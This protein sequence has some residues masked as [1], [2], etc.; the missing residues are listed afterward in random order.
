MK[1]RILLFLLF[2]S[3]SL[4]AQSA[5]ESITKTLQDYMQGSS[6]NQKTQLRSAFAENATLYLTVREEFKQLSADEYVSWFKG[7]SG[8]FNGRKAKILSIDVSK[9]IATAKVEILIPQ[10]KWRFI[11]LFLL[12]KMEGKTWKIISKTATREDSSKSGDHVLFVVSNAQFYG[13]SE[14]KTGNSFYEIVKA[15]DTFVQ[16]GYHVDFVSPKGGAIPVAYVDTSDETSKRLLYNND[17]MYAIKHTL[18]PEEVDYSLYKAIQYIGGGSSMFGVPEN[19]NIQQI[20][21]DIYEKNEGIVSSVC[22]GTAGI[23]NLKTKSGNYLVNGKRVS[24]YP[25]A[26]EHK[27]RAYYSTFPFKIT[28]T[29]E[30]RG[31]IFKHSPRNTAHV[32][33]DGRLVT[34]QNWLS[35]TP[36]AKAIIE[37][38]EAD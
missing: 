28:Q 27:D 7:E 35:S 10:R 38:L 9:D 15:Y 3:C 26:F 13:D 14:M 11:D 12:K 8:T 33:V 32:E 19:E 18:S 25:D 34:G 36:V 30:S 2:T 6:Y 1:I 5:Q 24:G 4:L 29:I 20:A 21:M 22:H 23:V 17:F 37:I 16:A 31:G